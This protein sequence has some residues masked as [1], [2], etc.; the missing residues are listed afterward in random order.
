[1]LAL[2]G[3]FDVWEIVGG[4]RQRTW[5]LRRLCMGDCTFSCMRDGP[6]TG[7]SDVSNAG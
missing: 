2:G 6:D 3:L 5:A 4:Y 1:V 7:R